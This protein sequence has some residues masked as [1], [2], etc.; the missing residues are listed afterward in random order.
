MKPSTKSRPARSKAPA[1]KVLWLS[2]ALNLALACGVAL[3]L[4]HGP[5]TPAQASAPSAAKAS[6]PAPA[7]SEKHDAAP[8]PPLAWSQLE[9]QEFPIYISRLRGVGCPEPTVRHIIKGELDEIYADKR[10]E[11]ITQSGEAAHPTFSARLQ[12]DLE[13]LTLEED[14]LLA[15][16]LGL[17]PPASAIAAAN[18]SESQLPP[19]LR[20]TPVL[21]NM[22]TTQAL[23]Q[24]LVFREVDASALN[25]T[26]TQQALIGQM[27]DSF[28]Q[29]IGGMN[30]DP[31]NPE[32][33]SRWRKAQ[34][35]S[36]LQLRTLLG[37]DLVARYRVFSR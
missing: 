32:Y 29:K 37:D 28:L 15:Q 36:D 33:M 22:V 21:E 7:P 3:L 20:H 27:R 10:H 11:L 13:E 19:P 4:W 9:S 23:A 30:Q 5:K 31:N 25:L 35:E 18:P 8:A 12:K 17:A 26:P 1:S 6:A 14:R 24:P 34:Y 2:L 16:L